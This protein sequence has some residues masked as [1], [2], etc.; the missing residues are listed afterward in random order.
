MSAPRSKLPLSAYLL[1]NR[2]GVILK[3]DPLNYIVPF[4]ASELSPSA[5]PERGVSR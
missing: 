3:V 5:G 1:K 2:R 4:T